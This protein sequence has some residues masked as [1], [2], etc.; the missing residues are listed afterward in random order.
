MINFFR[1]IRKRLA[2]NNQFVRYFRYA[3]GEV[4]L[5]MV[6]IFMALQL[7]NWN[8]R[9]Q[10][11]I[12]FNVILEQV[13]NAVFYDVEKFESQM[14]HMNNQIQRLDTI[15][16]FSDSIPK[17][18]LPYALYDTGF[19]NF[20]LYQSDVFFYANDLQS[21]YQN[22]ERN[23]LI[24]QI[25]G[26]LSLVRTSG[27]N[28]YDINNDMLSN[29][30]ISEDLAFPEMNREDLNEGW[31]F[32]DSLYYSQARLD[33]LQK[34]LRTEKYQAV[35]KTY[36][37]QKIAYKRGAQAK[38]NNGTSILNLIK[39]YNP[40]VRVIY[41]NVGIIGTALDGYDDV[42]G[43]S[44]PMQRTD[45]ENSIWEVELYLKQG[46]LKFRCNDSWLRN[47]GASYSEE[48]YLS[49]E[50]MPDG[51]N[52]YVEEG[53]YHVKLDLSNYTYEFTKLNK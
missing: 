3:F 9:R 10:Q 4:A 25:S 53:T 30:L 34:D 7:Q 28:V 16:Q 31:I 6:G 20:K 33:Q 37:S 12:E 51:N 17:K 13:Y 14:G 44:T 26:Y 39:A 23:E 32:Y 22:I 49:G 47:W 27:G 11:E 42:G 35:L 38:F 8:E 48:N 1:N 19:D 5:I 45:A 43:R 21:D 36:R 46:T 18:Y 52:I 40:D 15:I 50:A 41:E 2:N 29:F 24:K